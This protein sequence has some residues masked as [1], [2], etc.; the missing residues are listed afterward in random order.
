MANTGR[1]SAA[2]KAEALESEPTVIEYDGNEYEVPNALDLPV[3]IL[4]VSSELEVLRVIL[5]DDQY[6]VFRKTKPT[7]R[8]LKEFG[9]MVSE[10]AGFD[11][12]G[13]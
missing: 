5:G 3:E 12:L 1:V 9:E 8:K 6:K 11:D 2:Q 7:L 4:E 13:K 10:V